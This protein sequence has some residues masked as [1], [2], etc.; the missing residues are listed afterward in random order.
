LIKIGGKD[1]LLEGLGVDPKR[2]INTSEV[3]ARKA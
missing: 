3:E 2:G 1:H